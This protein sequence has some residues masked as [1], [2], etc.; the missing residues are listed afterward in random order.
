MLD[1][2]DACYYGDDGR[3]LFAERWIFRRL[4]GVGESFVR[5]SRTVADPGAEPMPDF[6]GRLEMRD[7][8]PIAEKSLPR[9]TGIAVDL[10]QG[11]L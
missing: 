11:Y 10:L 6:T 4:N 2:R 5:W 1:V 9:F 8:R 3:F 7:G